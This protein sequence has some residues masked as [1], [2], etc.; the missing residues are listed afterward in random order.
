MII[1]LE[2]HRLDQ[3]QLCH[4]CFGRPLKSVHLL[5][6][7]KSQNFVKIVL[8][9]ETFR[10]EW[11]QIKCCEAYQ[12]MESLYCKGRLFKQCFTSLMTINKN[13]KLI[14]EPFIT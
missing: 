6:I 8:E 12:G 2:K 5:C 3:F 7:T 4:D 13:G 9:G 11:I 10:E 1:A 14:C